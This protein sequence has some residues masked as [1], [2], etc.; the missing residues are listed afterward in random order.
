VERP[1]SQPMRGTPDSSLMMPGALSPWGTL[2]LYATPPPKSFV[3]VP[4]G[5]FAWGS[6]A[7]RT[8]SGSTQS[9]RMWTVT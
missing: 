5:E 4:V 7:A 2:S 9:A 8:C 6:W 3:W 1:V